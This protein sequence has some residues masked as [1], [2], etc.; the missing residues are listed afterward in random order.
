MHK[1]LVQFVF[2]LQQLQDPELG[3]HVGK[4]YQLAIQ[5]SGRYLPKITTSQMCRN[6]L[7]CNCIFTKRPTW[8][9]LNLLDT[10][11]AMFSF[12]AH[13]SNCVSVL[14]IE[15]ENLFNRRFVTS[16]STLLNIVISNISVFLLRSMC[17]YEFISFAV[18]E[19][20]GHL[21]S[22]SIPLEAGI[23]S[24]P[25]SLDC[26]TVPFKARSKI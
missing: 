3:S 10:S 16:W 17:K 23:R 7:I 12:V 21:V 25:Y 22:P 4:P 26:D 18:C 8:W 6:S 19:Q 14:P 2:S 11:L 5:F 20:L 15:I 9:H 1:S 24:L 13:I